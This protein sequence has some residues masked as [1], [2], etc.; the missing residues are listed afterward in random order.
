M[1]CHINCRSNSQVLWLC[2]KVNGLWPVALVAGSLSRRLW[3][4]GIWALWDSPAKNRGIWAYWFTWWLQ[5]PRSSTPPLAP[6]WIKWFRRQ[7]DSTFF[8]EGAWAELFTLFSLTTWKISFKRGTD[9]LSLI[10]LLSCEHCLSLPMSLD[11][12]PHELLSYELP[13]AYH[14]ILFFFLLFLLPDINMMTITLQF[15]WQM[16]IPSRIYVRL[17]SK[18]CECFHCSYSLIMHCSTCWIHLKP[19]D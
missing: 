19:P 2:S 7:V 5:I 4:R 11:I 9:M 12:A 3:S 10:L 8:G 1:R 18:L 15:H 6:R 13:V 17:W 16:L 14:I